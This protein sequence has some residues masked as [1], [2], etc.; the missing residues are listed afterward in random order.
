MFHIQAGITLY[1]DR[2]WSLVSLRH[3]LFYNLF[4]IKYNQLC[5]D[6]ECQP[7]VSKVESK[8]MEA[9]NSHK[10]HTT[11]RFTFFNKP[12]ANNILH[13]VYAQYTQ[14]VKDIKYP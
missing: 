12:G 14:K 8:L 1:H 11:Y 9:S 7:V 3:V 5:A 4:Y 6:K 2:N 10:I 13:R